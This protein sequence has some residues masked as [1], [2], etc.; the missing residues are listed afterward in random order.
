MEAEAHEVG[1]GLAGCWWMVS[2]VGSGRAHGVTIL[3]SVRFQCA[4][5]EVEWRVVVLGRILP[6]E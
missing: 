2:P 3:L 6:A 4:F 5:R 1:A